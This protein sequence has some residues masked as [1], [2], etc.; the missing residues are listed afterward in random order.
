VHRSFCSQKTAFFG[1]GL[2]F[3]CLLLYWPSFSNDYL[4][5]DDNLYI[6]ENPAVTDGVS[7]RGLSWAAKT[8]YQN[9]WMPLTWVSYQA[10]ASVF[11]NAAGPKLVVNFVLHLFNG[12]LLMVLFRG[13]GVKPLVAILG[14]GVFLLHPASVETVAWAASRKGLLAGAFGLLAAVCWIQKFRWPGLLCLALSM[15]CKQSWVF[16]P[17]VFLFLDL[18]RSQKTIMERVQLGLAFLLGMAGAAIAVWANSEVP[19]VERVTDL[20]PFGNRVGWAGLAF[21]DQL[22][23]VLLPLNPGIS[24]VAPHGVWAFYLVGGVAFVI[25]MFSLIK[26]G[27]MKT[28][29]I[30]SIPL[31]GIVWFVAALFPTLGLVPIGD[32]WRAERFLYP[33]LPGF[34]VFLTFGIQKMR[35]KIW[36]PALLLCL[37][38]LATQSASYLSE[39]KSPEGLFRRSFEDE[40]ETN[41]V[42]AAKL[43]FFASKSGD[44]AGA[45]AW[46][47]KALEIEARNID[48]MEGLA[49]MKAKQ[50]EIEQGRKLLQRAIELRPNR[51]S[52]FFNLALCD[53]AEGNRKE[54][55]KNL[56]KA[57]KR[58]ATFVPARDLERQ[59]EEFSE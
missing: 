21:L 54:A 27:P 3:V 59:L 22:R 31:V 33:A 32:V 48:A 36:V 17:G 8:R 34:I 26:I 46:F 12:C 13:L 49:V 56:N 37:A 10:E 55:W 14:A 41:H 43:G 24:H 30:W 44:D 19:A 29:V 53:L 15:M 42:A 25:G 1:G 40:P 7:F 2:F 57:L 52:L 18:S 47:E 20:Q 35:E 51:A 16:L 9:N 28:G 58:D 50:G 6:A 45:F 39:W 11:G 5:H 23:F 38:A 4:W